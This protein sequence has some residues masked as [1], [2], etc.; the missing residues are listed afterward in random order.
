MAINELGMELKQY[1]LLDEGDYDAVIFGVINLGLQTVEFQGEVKQPATFIRLILEI[2][3]IT[4]SEGNSA[5]IQKKVKLT[6]SVDKGNYAK[7][8]VA[9]G[10]KVTTANI[11]NYLTPAALQGLLGKTASVKIEHFN[12]ADGKRNMVQDISRLDPRLP[13][14]KGTKKHFFFN[15]F[16]PDLDVFKD[17]VTI[18]GKK[19]IMGA[20][21][22][23]N[24]PKE[25][26]AA[27]VEVQEQKE[28][29]TTT[30]KGVTK[31]N[32]SAIE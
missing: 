2:P 6:S 3:S 28:S 11:S 12:T 19:E 32:T 31:T 26:H 9:L 20:L 15:P 5:T 22:S 7:L 24:F 8:L 21:N 29:N 13:Q 30:S 17:D 1:N 27:W 23:S 10:E 14:P 4:D 18:Y 25:L 16:N